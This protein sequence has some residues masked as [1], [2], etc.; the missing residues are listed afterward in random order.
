MRRIE[1]AYLVSV[2]TMMLV[3]VVL[4]LHRYDEIAGLRHEPAVSA[5]AGKPRTIDTN[6]IRL[7]IKQGKL[8]GQ[9]A[10]FYTPS[11]ATEGKMAGLPDE[12]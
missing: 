9:E 3:I 5:S 2:A 11:P 12:K 4:S 7:Q 6:Q 10:R 8:S 1:V